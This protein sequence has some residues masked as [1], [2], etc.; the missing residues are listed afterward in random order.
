MRIAV[1]CNPGSWYLDDLTRAAALHGHHCV[2]VRFPQITATMATGTIADIDEVVNDVPG[3]LA[4]ADAVIVRTMPPGSLEQV[5]FRMDALA[6]LEHLL[7]LI[8]I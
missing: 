6:R 5:V 1:L 8:H 2:E 4:E 3:Q 7:S